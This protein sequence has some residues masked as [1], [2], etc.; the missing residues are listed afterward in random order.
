M[1]ILDIAIISFVLME[2]SNVL[3]MYFKPDF[4]YGNSI[5]VFNKWG[6]SK[7]DKNQHL[8]AKYLVNWVANCKL[9]FI[10]LLIVIL[11]VGDET[12]KIY[13]VVAM[14]FSI[15]TYFLTLHPIIS[16]LDKQG[17]IT[18]RGYS[19]TLAKM[20]SGFLIMFLAALIVYIFI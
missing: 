3:I 5:S 7:N 10:A 18:P 1:D 16:S 4:K 14:I 19:K 13:A 12:M 17:E 15:A 6:E 9:I 2:A 11:V 20:I 8:F